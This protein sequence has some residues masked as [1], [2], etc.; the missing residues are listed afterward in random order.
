[1]HQP[2][3]ERKAC[4]AQFEQQTWNALN[5]YGHQLLSCRLFLTAVDPL[6]PPLHHILDA[7]ETAR[8]YPLMTTANTII[9]SATLTLGISN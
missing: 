9:S 1:M 6:R 3:G 7:L 5:H 8:Q 2:E 4:A